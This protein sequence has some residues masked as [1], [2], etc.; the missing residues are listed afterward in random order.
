MVCDDYALL[1][2]RTEMSNNHA[3]GYKSI[4]ETLYYYFAKVRD[5]GPQFKVMKML[6]DIRVMRYQADIE[7][8]GRMARDLVEVMRG[9]KNDEDVDQLLTVKAGIPDFNVDAIKKIAEH[10][11]NPK[12]VVI[13][14]SSQ[15]YDRVM[16]KFEEQLGINYD[17]AKIP[18]NILEKTMKVEPIYGTKFNVTSI[19]SNVL[20]SLY[21]PDIDQDERKLCL[22]QVEYQ[23]IL[24]VIFNLLPKDQGRAREKTHLLKSWDD[25][26]LWYH[27]DEKFN[28]PLVFIRIKILTKDYSFVVQKSKYDSQ[29]IDMQRLL[30]ATM[31]EEVVKEYLVAY[32][33]LPNHLGYQFRFQHHQDSLEFTCSGYNN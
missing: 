16:T 5:E 19:P 21:E 28:E 24:P 30:F 32:S 31:W 17:V 26:D 20:D 27:K 15:R 4:L 9:A 2:I 10:L 18:Q 29:R 6:K 11:A 3:L 22:P 25:A 14:L 12:K 1:N 8:S 33:V 13:F 7:G 23:H